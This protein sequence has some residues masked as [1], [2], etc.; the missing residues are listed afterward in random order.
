MHELKA[1]TLVDSRFEIIERIGAGG[2]GVVYKAR[3]TA[4]DRVVALK[5]LLPHLMQDE[6]CLARFELEAQA[7]AALKHK[8]ISLFYAYGVWHGRAPYIAMEYL[9]SSD[10]SDMLVANAGRLSWKRT[11]NIA[12]QV[13][14][15]VAH[16]HALGIVHRDLK[17][18]N[19]FVLNEH[20]DDVVK[21]ADFGLAKFY[22][23]D[24]NSR[25]KLTQTG[26]T[27][28]SPHY[29]S[30]EQVQGLPATPLCDVYSIGCIIYECLF[31][32]P[33]YDGDS[34]MEI[35]SNHLVNAIPLPKPQEAKEIPPA[36]LKLLEGALAKDPRDR[37][38]SAEELR[39]AICG[40]L[41]T[42]V[43]VPDAKVKTVPKAASD[44]HAR[45][46]PPLVR[47][48]AFVT[49]ASVI[50]FGLGTFYVSRH[51]TETTNANVEFDQNSL[52]QLADQFHPT[53]A[54][55]EFRSR[56]VAAQ[57]Q[58]V[59]STVAALKKWIP[60]KPIEGQVLEPTRN[61]VLVAGLYEELPLVHALWLTFQKKIERFNLVLFTEGLFVANDTLRIGKD[62]A[63]YKDI[64][65]LMEN[66]AGHS[67]RLTPDEAEAAAQRAVDAAKR[68][69]A[70]DAMMEAQAIGMDYGLFDQ[71]DRVR[72]ALLKAT[73]AAQTVAENN[74]STLTVSLCYQLLLRDSYKLT[75]SD[76]LQYLRD[77]VNN[78]RKRVEGRAANYDMLYAFD[79]S[80]SAMYVARG[81]IKEALNVQDRTMHVCEGEPAFGIECF[82][83]RTELDNVKILADEKRWNEA[84]VIA[85]RVRRMNETAIGPAQAGY[86]DHWIAN[87]ENALHGPDAAL[88]A[89]RAESDP[90]NLPKCTVYM[91]IGRPDLAQ[92]EILAAVRKADPLHKAIYDSMLCRIYA[93]EG[94]HTKALSA[95]KEALDLR[96][97]KT[98]NDKAEIA[99]RYLEYGRVL[100]LIGKQDEAKTALT[101]AVAAA[102]TLGPA[103]EAFSRTVYSELGHLYLNSNQLNLAEQCFEK[104]TESLGKK[105]GKS[106]D[107]QLSLAA[108]A[109]SKNDLQSAR[110]SANRALMNFGGQYN[111][112]A[113]RTL[114]MCAEV[115]ATAGQTDQAKR[116][117]AA[118][119]R[120]WS[121]CRRENFGTTVAI[122]Y[123]TA[124]ALGEKLG[125]DENSFPGQVLCQI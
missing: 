22:D 21:V 121:V 58:Y 14:D 27:V 61:D 53:L 17:P 28:G 98:P 66:C 91:Q 67:L 88:K 50:A 15:A 62:S 49:V 1:K 29:M 106:G 39:A 113:C 103:G 79:K 65:E 13:S 107:Y 25:Q 48:V 35:L 19:I 77:A 56:P 95:A 109:L 97:S 8:N 73:R 40:A 124:K 92:T 83:A 26:A 89:M 116:M 36:V 70:H 46:K 55:A 41:Q 3:Q 93:F 102:E 125:V 12:A 112:Y 30:P 90:I 74:D 123:K 34:L 117:T 111:W 33:P 78:E 51:P 6:N 44:P 99:N 76:R 101:R 5:V 10:L 16:A 114:T 52:K 32:R 69:N 119:L 31:G 37:Y 82:T 108:L 63:Y 68:H 72:T 23:D 60:L 100:N 24:S 120:A 45:R 118:A 43:S 64:V 57:K 42:C 104:T 84:L 75:D 71:S 59:V 115:L 122:E 86:A 38:Q 9:E 81:Q 47:I 85:R 20:G 80:L 110:R 18:S 7:L 94:N 54:S 2:M 4:L 11:L 87:C 105:M 96:I